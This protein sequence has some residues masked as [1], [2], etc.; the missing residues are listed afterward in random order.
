GS[1]QRYQGT[2]LWKRFHPHAYLTLSKAMDSHNVGRGRGG[3]AQALHRVQA[4]TLVIGI[5]SDVLFPVE[6]QVELARHIAHARLELIDSLYG[7]DGF[8][9]EA[10]TIA[11]LVEFFMHG[12]ADPYSRELKLE[13]ELR[14]GFRQW[15]KCALPGTEPF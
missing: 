1:Y 11:P 12:C 9:V 13:P 6:E 15:R 3:V 7:H 5:R 4:R 2:K 10:E 8:L 14:S